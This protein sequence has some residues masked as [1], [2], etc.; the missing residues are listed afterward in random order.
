MTGRSKTTA[1]K[2]RIIPINK[3]IHPLIEK[4][5]D[6]NNKY[7]F[8]NTRG[9][10]MTYNSFRKDRWVPLM[11]SLNMNHKAHDCRHTFA[12]LMDN[13]GAKIGR[14]SCREREKSEVG[15]SCLG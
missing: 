3:K 9:N 10:K 4:R 15:G 7:L 8:V 1:G 12:T 11:D 13:V 6:E 14:A 2:N 5:M